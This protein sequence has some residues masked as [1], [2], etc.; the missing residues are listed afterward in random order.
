MEADENE[1]PNGLAL[2]PDGSRLYVSNTRPDPYIVVYTLNTDG[3]LGSGGRFADIPYG[4]DGLDG[5]V[6]DGM[7]VDEAGRVFCT[8]AG[9]AW[10]FDPDGTKLGVIE[11]PE[12]PANLAFGG[13]DRRTLF[14][15]ARTSVYSIR[16]Q[17][18]GMPIVY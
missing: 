5:G 13:E 14:L 15:T 2:S 17:T 1:R 3:S 7:K 10:V 18:P 9:G 12:L 6:P 4:P 16:V 8:G 11:A